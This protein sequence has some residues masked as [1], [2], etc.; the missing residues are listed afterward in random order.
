MTLKTKHQEALETADACEKEALRVAQALKADS[1]GSAW[2]IDETLDYFY[3]QALELDKLSYEQRQTHPFFGLSLG[4]KDLFCVKGLTT[5]AGSRILEH[6]K[7]PYDA[8]LWQVLKT[9]GA[10]LG[11][12]CAMDE[13]AMGSFSDTSAFGKVSIPGYPEHSAGGSSGGSAAAVAAGIVDF[14]LGSD[15]GGSVRQP[16]S[17]CSLVGYKP[18]YGAF[19]RH[20]M[21][22]YA[23]SL[24]QAGFFTKTIEDLH[25]ILSQDIAKGDV[26]D[27]TAQ[28]L[29]H[30][31]IEAKS[32]WTV[33]FFESFLTD[34]S[35]SPE[36]TQAYAKTL[37]DLRQKG[38]TLVPVHSNYMSD[39][40]K[41]YY[42]IACSE[43]SS[44]LARY[45]GVFFGEKLID[46]TRLGDYW[47]QVAQYRSE[48][49]GLEVQKRIMLGSFILSAENFG[50][51]YQKAV[52][53][54]KA[55]RQ[56]FAQIFTTVDTLVLPVAPMTS[57]TWDKIK[58]MTSAQIYT[59]DCMT[60]PFSLAGLPAISMPLHKTEQGLGI[61]MQF[62]GQDQSDYTLIQ[63]L[64]DFFK[65]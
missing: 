54:R 34:S 23:S 5:T 1:S 30:P 28:G 48:Y 16:A 65:N 20:G 32:R 59:S 12:K 18:S 7:S 6:F 43:A 9:K 27:M 8:D 61:G 56:E 31:K 57:P 47:H 50:A 64:L 51:M 39:A 35:V 17:F 14:S 15:T 52:T 13:F 45:Q 24:D 46:K 33:G 36:V 2:H 4:L 21:I 62:V 19:S 22:A 25:Y 55:L 60:V 10:L 63:N 38:V 44:N 41:I 11:A 40:A 29:A 37:E 49:F 58:H 26:K 42:I 53:L 3:Q